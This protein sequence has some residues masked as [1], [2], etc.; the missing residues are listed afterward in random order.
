V[1]LEHGADANGG[2]N[3]TLTTHGS[4]TDPDGDPLSISGSGAGDVTD[5]EDGT[6]S[7]SYDPSGDGSGSVTV[8]ASDGHGGSTTDSFAWVA[9]D[10]APEVSNAAPDV[11]GHDGDHFTTS[12]A[13]ADPDGDPL[14]ISASGAGTVTPHPDGTWTWTFTPPGDGTG[15]VTVSA[16]DGYGG[17]VSD[18]FTWTAANA[19]PAVDDAAANVTGHEGDTL[20]ANGSFSDPDGDPISIGGSGVGHVTDHHDG[21]WS[22][23]FTPNDDGNGSVKVTA[24]DGFGGTVSDTFTWSSANVAPSIVSLIPDTRKVLSGA[25]VTWTAVA[26]DPGTAD[27]FT[28]W[29]DGGGGFAGGLRT[30]YTRSYDDC[31]TY[32]LHAR[33]EDD[34]GG[35]AQ[36]TSDATVTVVRAA[37]LS[38]VDPGGSTAV[39]TGQVLPVKVFVGCGAFQNDLQPTIDLLFHGESYAAE[40]TSSADR[41]GVMRA[42]QGQYQYN[43][44]VPRSLGG[45]DLAKGDLVTVR[46][47]PFG[48]DGGALRIVLQIRK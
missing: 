14:N 15:S 2:H 28:W 22:W 19:P 47:R 5:H 33:I 9:D 35:S 32:A 20:T 16:S 45:V 38:P 42:N 18:T 21:T 46:V 34:D 48:P 41:P 23:S 4:F 24:S 6:W 30:T 7:W 29:F 43:L 37:A 11:T 27:T 12:G 26:T 39:N 44:R 1:V 36:A 40:T 3:D 10:H 25:D 17:T 13:F 8:T 31:G